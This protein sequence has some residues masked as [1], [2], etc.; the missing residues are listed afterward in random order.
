MAHDATHVIMCESC[1]NHTATLT[2]RATQ[3]SVHGT[4]VHS[5]HQGKGGTLE[6]SYRS[7]TK[8]SNKIRWE[9]STSNNK[10]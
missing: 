5:H 2:L 9:T 7:L 10:Y 4:I 8:D 1:V 3:C 6:H